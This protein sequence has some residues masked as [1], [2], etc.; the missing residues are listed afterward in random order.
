MGPFRANDNFYCILKMEQA[1][2]AVI[3]GRSQ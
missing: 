1:L 2:E 3:F